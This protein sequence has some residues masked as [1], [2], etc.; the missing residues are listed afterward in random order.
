MYV[1]EQVRTLFG[2]TT[3]KYV[4]NKA[5]GGAAGQKGTRYED[6]FALM[7]IGEA[8]KLAFDGDGDFAKER[9]TDFY[10]QVPCFV[11]DLI[12]AFRGSETAEHY[13]LKNQAAPSWGKGKKSISSDFAKQLRL[14]GATKQITT[15]TLV[16]NSPDLATKLREKKPRALRKNTFV[17]YFPPSATLFELLEH[18]PMREALS[19]LLGPDPSDDHLVAIGRVM[20]GAWAD[21]GNATSLETLLSELHKGGA[22]FLRPL[23][24]VPDLP[25][26]L[27]N[28]LDAIPD[29]AYRVERGFFRWSY[30]NSDSGCYSKHCSTTEF[31]AF[32]R[33]VVLKYPTT[34]ESLEVELA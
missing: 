14:G 30:G 3:A 20:Q 8:A 17:C 27:K 15:V 12:V 7:K 34:F 33:R 9:D 11:D 18:Q 13:Q 26:D 6:R 10:S 25:Q 22:P 23:N 21:A 32:T 5:R 28:I 1:L 24:S 19:E 31:I 4:A 16:V 2:E 29:F